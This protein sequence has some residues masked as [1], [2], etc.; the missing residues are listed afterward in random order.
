MQSIGEQLKR[1]RDLRGMSIEEVAKLTRIPPKNLALLEADRLEALP[2]DVFTK[3]F[4]RAYARAVGADAETFV[5][6]FD[7]M[8]AP[9]PVVVPAPVTIMHDMD[10]GNRFGMAIVVVILL[11]LFTLALSIVLQPRH[12]STPAEL[13]SVTGQGLDGDSAS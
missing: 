5:A 10:R 8:R 4:I 9:E 11:I 7:R 1:E 6:R 2:G 13:S 12:R 3:G